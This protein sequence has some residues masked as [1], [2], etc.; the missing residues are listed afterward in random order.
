MNHTH[1]EPCKHKINY[2][3]KCDIVTCSNCTK[4]WKTYSNIVAGVPQIGF[5]S[6]TPR[7]PFD[8]KIWCHSPLSQQQ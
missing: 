1:P 2:C 3:E 4:E 5:G 7:N 6:L 8:N